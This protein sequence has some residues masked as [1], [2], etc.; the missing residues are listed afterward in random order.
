MR[1]VPF[2]LA[3]AILL[4]AV[5]AAGRGV[6]ISAAPEGS[7]TSLTAGGGIGAAM[8]R[9]LKGAELD[10]G[11]E[12]GYSASVWESYHYNYTSPSGARIDTRDSHFSYKSNGH[13]YG[14][15][16]IRFARHFAAD[17]LVGWAGIYEGRRVVPVTLRASCFWKGY[18]RDGWKTFLEAGRCFAD[19][20]AGKPVYVAK[21][22]TGYRM[23]LDRRFALDLAL[24]LQGAYDH[25]LDV[26]DKGREEA[27]QDANLRRSDSGYLSLNF[28]LALCF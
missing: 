5:P 3:F 7:A 8:G 28:S 23:M 2:L 15:A 14:F 27:V 26:Y 13:L 4:A 12:W 25:P 6:G 1:P 22:G 18:D 16:G 20:F 10:Y 17:A 9:F 11:V 21:L 24:S 19:S